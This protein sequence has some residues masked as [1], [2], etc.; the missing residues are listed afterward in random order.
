MNIKPFLRPEHRGLQVI[1]TLALSMIFIIPQISQQ[2]LNDAL[3]ITGDLIH[4]RAVY[5]LT[6]FPNFE[7]PAMVSSHSQLYH[8]FISYFNI[9]TGLTD[10]MAFYGMSVINLLMLP[11]A[12]LIT[13]ILA[14]R[15]NVRYA[16]FAPLL[17]LNN[18]NLVLPFF[19]HADQHLI[20][21][22]FGLFTFVILYLD[23][24]IFTKIIAT[25]F[26]GITLNSSITIW[27]ALAITLFILEQYRPR[28]K[29]LLLCLLALLL[30]LP[31]LTPP[32]AYLVFND[33]SG[34]LASLPRL[35]LILLAAFVLLFS[36]YRF[37][38]HHTSLKRY[39][40][41][42]AGSILSFLF[43]IIARSSGPFSGNILPETVET[44]KT[45]FWS[46]LNII[47]N[48][49]VINP[50][51][52]IEG[53]DIYVPIV[54]LL[55]FLSTAT[56][57]KSKTKPNEITNLLSFIILIP[58]VLTLLR[59]SLFM[60][61]YEYFTRTPL[62]QLHPGRIMSIS[63]FLLPIIVVAFLPQLKLYISKWGLLTITTALVINI[64]FISSFASRR[65][66]P[67]W[68][69]QSYQQLLKQ[70]LE[71]GIGEHLSPPEGRYA[72]RFYH[73]CDVQYT[74]GR[75]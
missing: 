69:Q 62:Y 28:Y 53:F 36:I 16:F 49:F 22:F 37:D 21:I 44:A 65:V 11:L 15:V 20:F 56:F 68:T 24:T 61:S 1:L 72:C 73:H 43:F 31:F 45:A 55:L 27:L 64:A 30:Y 35:L 17:F 46:S 42:Y 71:L 39:V 7:T 3:P 13:L 52:G 58:I 41:L 51:K 66:Y 6:N 19:G 2:L 8:Y 32:I 18:P 74:G 29:P 38:R 10:N 14:R 57:F 33:Y 60:V 59:L 12:G 67:N 47:N 63:F 9:L 75:F 4:R 34:T 40:F 23:A 50:N 54:L 70:S 25:L 5:L 48:L 26:L